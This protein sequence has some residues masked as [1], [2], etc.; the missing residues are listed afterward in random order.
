[1]ARTTP[2]GA[3]EAPSPLVTAVRHI[4]AN[5]GLDRP[6]AALQKLAEAVDRPGVVDD[7]LTGK[8]IGHAAHPL[9]TDL[10]IGFWTSTGVLDL[11]GGRSSR[12]AA[13]RL[14]ALGILSAVPTVATGLAEWLRA[15]TSSRRVGVVHA[16][17]NGVGLGFYVAS[18]VARKRGQRIKGVL[19]ALVGATFATI[20]GYLGGHMTVARKVGTRDPAFAVPGDPSSDGVIAPADGTFAD[21][22]HAPHAPDTP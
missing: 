10:P 17:A 3:A 19:L 20:G 9:M 5:E 4:E 21:A 1:M 11:I 18:W 8:P 13:D 2:D 15:D 12:K 22:P 7:V 14:L 6:A 16:N